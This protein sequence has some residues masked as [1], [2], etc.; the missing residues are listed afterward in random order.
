[1]TNFSALRSVALLALASSL[2][3]QTNQEAARRLDSLFA[4]YNARTPG[5]AV[6]VVKDG[7]VVFSKGYGM[8]DLGHDIPITT[9]TVF[10]IASVSKQFTA[11]AI[12]LL[13]SEGRISFEDDVRKYIPELPDYG[14]V[15]KVR[16]L[17]AHTSGLRDQA[18]MMS[19]AGWR[20]GDVQTTEQ[21]M[22]LVAKQKG[23]NFTP[24]SAFNYSNTGYTLLAEIIRRATG[25]PFSAY[26]GQKIFAPL[27]MTSTRV[28]TNHEEIVRHAAESYERINGRYYRQ[29]L[30]EANAGPSNVLT[31]VEDLAKWVLNF[32]R[33]SVG[34]SQLIRAFNEPSRLD[35]GAKVVLRVVDGDTILHAKGQNVS[36]YKGVTNISHGGHAGSF[37]T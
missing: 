12:Y 16:H 21:I 26:V 4:S 30:N 8:A 29:P 15:I 27:G 1:M 17:L 9:R 33:P 13:E 25:T 14:A 18:A 10:N 31:T 37:R 19:L 24:G 36:S 6:A 28:Q 2:A 7:E 32:E 23:L 5:A 34:T 22:R 3:A 35:N 11:F 20:P